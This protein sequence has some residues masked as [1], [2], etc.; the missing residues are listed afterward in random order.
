MKAKQTPNTYEFPLELQKEYWN[1]M[2]SKN[3]F[4]KKTSTVAKRDLI[5]RY[6]LL[7]NA[8]NQNRTE[9]LNTTLNRK[10]QELRMLQNELNKNS[11][12]WKEDMMKKYMLQLRVNMNQLNFKKSSLEKKKAIFEEKLKTWKQD[13]LTKKENLS[14]KT[15]TY[16]ELSANTLS[17]EKLRKELEDSLESEKLRLIEN[18][19]KLKELS[20]AELKQEKL[21]EKELK[22][23]KN[24][25]LEVLKPQKEILKK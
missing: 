24:N 15:E 16:Q 8:F 6:E 13:I 14:K 20:I 21:A 3:E 2:K 9:E 19:M 7:E 23:E 5:T 11:K 17:L 18:Q 1:L 10:Y 25:Q 4:L 22:D 12:T